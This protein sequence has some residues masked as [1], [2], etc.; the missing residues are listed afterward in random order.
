MAQEAKHL[1]R[2]FRLQEQYCKDRSA[3]QVRLRA[4]SVPSVRNR[5]P[6]ERPRG[7]YLGGSGSG[8]VVEALERLEGIR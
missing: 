7:W 2:S 5:S 3:L 8:E 6:R 4:L 1:S